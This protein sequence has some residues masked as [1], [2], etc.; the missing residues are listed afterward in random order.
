MQ[1]EDERLSAQTARNRLETELKV[2]LQDIELQRDQFRADLWTERQTAAT[3]RKE[4]G[5]SLIE[6]AASIQ[7]L[8]ED[9]LRLLQQLI[10]ARVKSSEAQYVFRLLCS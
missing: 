6:A 5:E 10:E 1:L 4:L 8:R 7:V 9:N 3:V 2:A